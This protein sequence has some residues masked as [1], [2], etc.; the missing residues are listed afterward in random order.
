MLPDLRGPPGPTSRSNLHTRSQRHRNGLWDIVGIAVGQPVY[1][2]PG[3]KFRDKLRAYSYLSEFRLGE[4]PQKTADLA[5]SY[6][7]EGYTAVKLD[8]VD[9]HTS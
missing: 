9:V 1:N 4:D 6:V 3:G 2:L 7:D 5:L 8:P